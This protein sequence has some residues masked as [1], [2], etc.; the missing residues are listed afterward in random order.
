MPNI[1][2]RQIPRRVNFP[3]KLK[4]VIAKQRKKPWIADS[5]IEIDEGLER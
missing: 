5:N 3:T 1:T 4:Q 2:Q